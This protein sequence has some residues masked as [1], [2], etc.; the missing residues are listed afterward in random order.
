MQSRPLIFV[1]GTRTSRL[2]IR[3]TNGSVEHF[4][5]LLPHEFLVREKLDGVFHLLE[6]KIRRN[7]DEDD[8]PV[9]ATGLIP[10]AY[11]GLIKS[12]LAWGYKPNLDFWIFPY[13]WRQSNRVSG[14]LLARFIEEKTGNSTDGVDIVSHSMGGIITRSAHKYGAPIRRAIY[15]GCPHLG[16]PLA[17]FILHP[18]IDSRRFI[19]S[20]YDSYPLAPTL[21][22][23]SSNNESKK[24]LNERRKELFAKFPSM[25]ELLPDHTYLSKM[26]V[27]S[28]DGKPAFG[29]EETYLTN[30]WAFKQK[31]M[32]TAIN[33]ASAFK[34]EIGDEL[35]GDDV[36]LVC[37][38]N[39]ITFDS[40]KFRTA[41]HV[42]MTNRPTYVMQ[43]G[44]SLPYD[45]GLG[46]DGYV[47]T[48][49][50]MGTVS[51]TSAFKNT[52]FIPEAHTALPNANATAEVISRFLSA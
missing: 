11:G 33:D 47:P 44:F 49:S 25:Y 20:A 10:F 48:I 50:A 27:L 37:G 3:K 42:P 24:S 8:I 38:T 17:Y 18:E 34:A 32:R 36:L 35:S 1:P 21:A 5:P 51:E 26:P 52:V 29:V 4:W 23:H 28:A 15:I 45:S 6:T 14:Q 39:Q 7:V 12:I 46:G 22:G 9:V 2:A 16:S 19:G 43:R 31:D 40:I 41:Y 30:D 13:D